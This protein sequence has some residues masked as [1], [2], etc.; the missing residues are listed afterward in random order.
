M[1]EDLFI[2][3]PK[4]RPPTLLRTNIS[5][6]GNFSPFLKPVRMMN[7]Y[8]NYLFVMDTIQ[9][10]KLVAQGV[11][12]SIARIESSTK[13]SDVFFIITD[14]K[15]TSQHA[16]LSFA[17]Q[18]AGYGNGGSFMVTDA[19]LN[20]N[21]VAKTELPNSK[22]GRSFVSDCYED[23]C[24]I[25]FDIEERVCGQ[26]VELNGQTVV[27]GKNKKGV[28]DG[29]VYYEVIN[30][31]FVPSGEF[32]GLVSNFH[33]EVAI[34]QAIAGKTTDTRKKRPSRTLYT[35]A[36][37]IPSPEEVGNDGDGGDGAQPKTAKEKA[38][39]AAKAAAELNSTPA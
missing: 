21:L 30:L 33:R 14:K 10:I 7:A 17:D 4:N 27:Y 31:R 20:A 13:H 32:D 19:F 12:M 29:E 22:I 15:A 26:V 8:T 6:V 25:V 37:N 1:V 23:P 16:G 34:A 5:P 11:T 24:N 9:P 3:H 28:V 35:F 36:S 18:T 39:A 2:H 38:A